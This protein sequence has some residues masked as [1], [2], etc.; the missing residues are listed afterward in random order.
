LKRA[1][2]LRLKL[3]IV[4]FGKKFNQVAYEIGIESFI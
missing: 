2:A 4:F 3:P 1:V